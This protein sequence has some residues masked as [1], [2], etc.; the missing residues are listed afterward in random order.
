[1]AQ[2]P[3][4]PHFHS[5]RLQ[6]VLTELACLHT[7]VPDG[8]FAQKLSLWVD[9]TQAIGLCMVHNSCE[10]TQAKAAGAPP[11]SL[12]EAFEQARARLERTI[13]SGKLPAPEAL[14]L[15]QADADAAADL[16]AAYEPYRRYY[17]AQQRELESGVGPLR[18]KAREALGR[19]SP[20]LRQLAALD[21]AMDSMLCERESRLLYTVP[22]L[23]R[24]RFDQLFHA[25]LPAGTVA[26]ATAWLERFCSEMQSVLLAELDLRLQP[27]L[28]LMEALQQEQTQTA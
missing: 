1:M 19:A 16:G 15:G 8:A 24:I 21:A 20:P 23:L 18:A 9:Y 13:A 7:V 22:K 25:P 14:A 11:A 28:G 3:T 4:P 10:A 5:A 2:A 17:L 27:A 6:R 12:A 26:H